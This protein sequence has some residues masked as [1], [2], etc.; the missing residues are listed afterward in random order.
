M[1]SQRTLNPFILVA[2]GLFGMSTASLLPHLAQSSLVLNDVVRGVWYGLC[3]GL[4]MVGLI[5][6]H[7][8]R[9]AIAPTR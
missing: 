7:K 4:E 2:L 6:L 5:L 3:I 8:T 9:R 1:H